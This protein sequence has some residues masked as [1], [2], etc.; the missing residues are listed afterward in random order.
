MR[1][2][3]DWKKQA[4]TLERQFTKL[5]GKKNLGKKRTG[6]ARVYQTEE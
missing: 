4:R 6:E 5:R 3:N 1:A 2:R